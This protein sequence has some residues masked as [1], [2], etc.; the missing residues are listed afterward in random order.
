MPGSYKEEALKYHA[1]PV[2]G[3]IEVVPTKPCLTAWDLS[4]AYSPGVA[5]PCREIEK[6]PEEAF[7][8]TNR[9]NL[10]AVVSNGTAVLG[11]GNI[12]A[13]ASKPVMEGKGVLFK[14]FADIDVFDL[15]VDTQDPD[16]VIKICKLLEPT[17]GGINLEDIKAPDCFYIEETLK[18]EMEIPIFHDD[19][20]GTAIISGAGLLN[21]L[22]LTKKD[23]GKI[24]VVFSGAGASAIA[25]A[26]LYV[27]LGVE[28][29]NILLVDSRGTITVD[30]EQGMNDYKRE[31]AAPS[32][33]PPTLKDAMKGADVFVGLS[34]KDL[35][36]QDMVRGMADRPIVFA[37]ANPDPEITYPDAMEARP[38]AIVATGRSDYPNQVNNVLGFPFVFRGALDTHARGINEEMKVAACHAL[39]E[40]A[41]EDVPDAVSRAYHE[42]TFR[43]GPDYII[44]K[45]FD[46]R[47]L[48]WEAT[49]V[50]EAA[51]ITGVARR[52]LDLK[53]YRYALERKLGRR[54]QIM[55]RLVMRVKRDP[56][57][58]V[59]PEGTNPRI[60]RSIHT[61]LDEGLV[62]P[63][64]LGSP[65]AVAA[66]ARELGLAE[67]RWEI[68]DP[69][70]DER[71]ERYAEEYFKLR[72]RRGVNREEARRQ[73]E[74]PLVFGAMMVRLGE[75]DGMVAGV[76]RRL[77]DTVRPVLQ[78]IQARED[79]RRVA[80]VQIIMTK[81]RV[82][83]FADTVMTVDPTA[84]ELA[85]IALLAARV[86]RE[87]NEEPVIAM[88]SFS[89]FGSVR[90][91]ESEKVK[92]AVEIL[93]RKAPDLVV[94]GEI[95]ADVALMPETLERLYPT[96]QLVGKQPNVF[97]F[98]DLNAANTSY[99]LITKLSGAETIGP[100]L[101]GLQKPFQMLQPQSGPQEIAQ[102]ST[103]AVAE[104]QEAKK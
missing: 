73:V 72:V 57:R 13:L 55:Q 8:Y 1:L 82:V 15:E 54:W 5:E 67:T 47:V 51:M 59:Y 65:D 48:L 75:A 35:V 95:Q 31:F 91:P 39:A 102:M 103:I 77:P 100:I 104:A 68:V 58:I 3:K 38:D 85:E 63:V 81:D 64:L 43:F 97:V 56:R 27:H 71:R 2:P 53:E 16:E 79:V 19:Q 98:P 7:A 89:N 49:A 4:L 25:C 84:E 6:N 42:E 60:L 96:S 45:P 86:A 52:K 44:P 80:G 24:R 92:K 88:L 10:V 101:V 93:R 36:S 34:V 83:F 11:L 29:S 22:E 14:R 41:K 69:T 40:L 21:A 66:E 17:F 61:M 74:N 87:F 23:I 26:K 37:L 33:A 20:H 90:C 50:A 32:G 70:T 76:E 28:R 46:Y 12:G 99:K 62:R 9:S 78:I 30:R 18:R 94:D